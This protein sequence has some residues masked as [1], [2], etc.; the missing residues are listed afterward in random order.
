M[1]LHVAVVD[2]FK[3][4]LLC[5]VPLFKYTTVY[6]FINEYLLLF[7]QFLAILNKTAGILECTFWW[8]Y[9]LNSL[10]YICRGIIA[11]S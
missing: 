6:P 9:V 7:L 3:K 4:K 10:E 2:S 1:L 8:T 5:G 11:R